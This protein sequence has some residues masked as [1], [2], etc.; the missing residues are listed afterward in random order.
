MRYRKLTSDGDYSFGSGQKDFYRD[1]P[2][3]VGQAVKT[4]L[5]LW[6]GEWFLNV[7]DGTPYLI[8]VLGKQNK[9]TADTTIQNRILTTEG[10]VSIQ[11]YES[12]IDPD[13]RRMSV[14]TTV[15]TVYGPTELDVANYVRF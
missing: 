11:E 1:V 3:A 5:E 13:T 15:N 7:D 2:D 12:A 6:L 9:K 4:R 14:T 8:S 10:L